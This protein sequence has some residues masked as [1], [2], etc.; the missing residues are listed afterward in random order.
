MAKNK[1]RS[2]MERLQ[3]LLD[4]LQEALSSRQPAPVRIPAREQPPR[5]R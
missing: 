5:R 2:F 3:E 4:S 1:R